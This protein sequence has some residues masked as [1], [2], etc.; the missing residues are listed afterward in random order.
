MAPGWAENAFRYPGRHE[1]A[2]T[3]LL[4]SNARSPDIAGQVLPAASGSAASSMRHS[5]CFLLAA[6]D[7]LWSRAGGGRAKRRAV[8]S[9]AVG[10]GASPMETSEPESCALMFVA[11]PLEAHAPMRSTAFRCGDHGSQAG[12]AL[13]ASISTACWRRDGD[14][15]GRWSVKLF[16][17][18]YTL[19]SKNDATICRRR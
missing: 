16:G 3:I 8:R 1:A 15:A 5:R 2:K 12:R 9:Q 6:K 7:G 14:I 19:S 11:E 18:R 4:R 17:G 13:M 10:G